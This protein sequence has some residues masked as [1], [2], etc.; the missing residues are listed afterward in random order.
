MGLLTVHLFLWFR[1]EH[2]VLSLPLNV[3]RA[4]HAL[5]ALHGC[6]SQ[7]VVRGCV[8]FLVWLVTPSMVK[9][10]FLYFGLAWGWFASFTVL[11]LGFERLRSILPLWQVSGTMKYEPCRLPVL[12]AGIVPRH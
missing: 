11:G 9:A 8:F 6:R 1:F 10:E 12:L 2:T 7:V 3:L 5:H 4:L